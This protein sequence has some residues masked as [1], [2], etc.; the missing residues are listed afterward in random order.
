MDHAT[1]LLARHIHIHI[2]R[3]VYEYHCNAR[4]M[5]RLTKDHHHSTLVYGGREL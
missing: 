5:S 3:S 4:A 1:L 2:P